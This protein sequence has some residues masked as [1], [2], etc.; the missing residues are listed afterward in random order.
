MRIM[1]VTSPVPFILNSRVVANTTRLAWCAG[2]TDQRAKLDIVLMEYDKLKDE[3]TERIKQR[4]NFIYLNLVS[5]GLVVSFAATKDSA[6]PIGFLA[7]PWISIGFG[8]LYLM[9]DEKVSALARYTKFNLRPRLLDIDPDAFGWEV[10]PKRITTLT[11]PKPAGT[12]GKTP[13]LSRLANV[14]KTGQLLIDLL[15]FVTP[16]PVA[17]AAYGSRSTAVGRWPA[18][19][20]VVAV[21][22]AILGIFLLILMVLHSHLIE[23]FEDKSVWNHTAAAIPTNEVQA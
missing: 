11:T 18:Y 4:D 6:Q 5:I 16:V 8:W 3:S 12:D 13:M 19:V 7:I 22:E 15:M 17:L 1:A 9:N 10:R 20:V 23:R 14:P 21:A 2:M